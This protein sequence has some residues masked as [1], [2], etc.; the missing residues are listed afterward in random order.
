M[1]EEFESTS[2]PSE[3]DDSDSVGS[4]RPSIGLV[5]GVTGRHPGSLK[6][7]LPIAPTTAA[8]VN[9]LRFSLLPIACWKLEDLRFDFDSSF[10]KPEGAD[11]FTALLELRRQHAGAPL[12][13]FGH[14]DPTGKDD[15]NK[16]LSGRRALAVQALLVRDVAR[17]QK[18]HDEPFGGDDWGLR[19]VQHMLAALG[20]DPGIVDGKMGPKTKSAVRN[21]QTM[22]EGLV[23]DGDPGKQTR[24]ALI[25]NYMEFLCRDA[26]GESVTLTKEDFLARGADPKLRGDVQGCSEFNPVIVLSL[27]EDKQFA[28]PTKKAERDA[29]LLPDRRVMAFLFVPGVSIEPGRWPCPAAEDGPAACKAQFFPNADAR[30]S[31]RDERRLYE[32]THDTMACKFYDR[33]ARRS[34]CEVTRASLMVRLLNH[35]GDVIPC[36]VYRVTLASG[37]V[38]RNQ[39]GEDGWLIEQN[40]ETPSQVLVEWGYPPINDELTDDERQER[41]QYAG[42]FGYQLEVTLGAEAIADEKAQARVRLENLGYN[43]ERTLQENLI[44][45]QREYEVFPALG[46]LND[47]TREALRQA[48]DDGV[49]RD[50]LI[51]QRGSSEAG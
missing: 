6:R 47:D 19:S 16:T 15:Y 2:G 24:K 38:R 11:E 41:W 3:P 42:P 29:T 4:P 48:A 35:D 13:I 5:G 51:A 45:F 23:V 50:E 9:T 21:F 43:P 46:E 37:E 44:A 34:P 7:A 14:A 17:W 18:L 20:F 30:R 49:S 25:T 1:A 26:Q 33:L 31:P 32:V 40:V 28:A 36:A 22:E 8:G 12:S 39:T 10:I 27:D